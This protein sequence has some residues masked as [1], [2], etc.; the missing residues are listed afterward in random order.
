MRRG[1]IAAAPY[2]RRPPAGGGLDLTTGLVA[3]WKFNEASGNRV[4]EIGAY[5]LT[6]VNTVGTATGVVDATSAVFESVNEERLYM[7]SVPALE[8][9]NIDWCISCWIRPV[10]DIASPMGVWNK[11][12]D[13]S[14]REYCL[15][16][17]VFSIGYLAFIVRNAAN[18]ADEVLPSVTELS[19]ETW[20]HVVCCHDSVNDKLQIY[21][22]GVLDNE[23]AYAN[24]VYNGAVNPRD[25]SVGCDQDAPVVFNNSYFNGSIDDLRVYK[26]RALTAEEVAGLYAL[27]TP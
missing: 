26:N 23:V 12:Y 1:L 17:S 15:Y 27:G 22:D 19:L 25:F 11:W 14:E 3:H 20:Y 9:G 18:T 5:A 10:G 21:I 6:D 13:N 8:M 24:G 16:L 7:A 2:R 4:D